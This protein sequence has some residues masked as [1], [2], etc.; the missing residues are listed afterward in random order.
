MRFST[1]AE[2]TDGRSGRPAGLQLR[3]TAGARSTVGFS[4]PPLRGGD[5][6]AVPGDDEHGIDV[7][8]HRADG[9]ERGVDLGPQQG[10]IRA[11]RA[12]NSRTSSLFTAISAMSSM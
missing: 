11:G 5:G 8:A 1:C 12:M 10:G 9:L 2:E 4:P 7:L 3:G 6:A